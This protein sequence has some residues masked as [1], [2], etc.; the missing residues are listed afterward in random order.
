LVCSRGE[1][2]ESHGLY[3]DGCHVDETVFAKQVS[4]ASHS[5]DQGFVVNPHP[6]ELFHEGPQTVIDGG[7]RLGMTL[8]KGFGVGSR[9]EGDVHAMPTAVLIR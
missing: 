3:H 4:F 8:A 5:D 6:L 9:V 7:E 2:L 1:L